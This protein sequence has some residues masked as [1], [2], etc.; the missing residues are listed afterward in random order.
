MCGSKIDN[1]YASPSI[2]SKNLSPYFAQNDPKYLQ[3]LTHHRFPI[4]N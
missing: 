1:K 4:K 3:L 2:Q